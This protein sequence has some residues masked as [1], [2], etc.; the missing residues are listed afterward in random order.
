MAVVPARRRMR[1]IDSHA[2]LQADAFAADADV[3]VAAAE[4]AGVARVLDPAWDVA[5]CAGALD[6][7]A[8]H[9]FIDAAVGIHPH[10]AAKVD[11]AAWA[12]VVT[13]ADDRR[14]V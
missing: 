6:L 3:V 8:R 14:V 11:G 12:T 13:L 4:Q 7:A 1:L 2:H 9:P 10:V 5:S